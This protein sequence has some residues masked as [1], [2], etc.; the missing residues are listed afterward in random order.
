FGDP[1]EH[2]LWSLLEPSRLL[3]LLAHFVVF[4]RDPDT[5]AVTKKMCRYQQFRAVNKLVARVADGKVGQ[6]LIQ[7]TQGSGKSLTMVF[8]VLKLKY[9]RG[10]KSERLPNPNVLVLTDR[11]DLDTQIANTFVACGLPN[12]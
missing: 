4:E 11:I 1:V 12:P 10:V 7:H 6:G 5:G 3:D 2:G 9:H 8:A